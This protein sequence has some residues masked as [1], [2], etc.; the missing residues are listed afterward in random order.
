MGH[1]T[2]A[3]EFAARALRQAHHF[4]PRSGFGFQVETPAAMASLLA[5]IL[6]LTGFPDQA[7]VAASEA[8]AAAAKSGHSFSLC[9]AIS[10]GGLPVALWTGDMGEAR[11]LFELLVA[12]A[13]GMPRMELR[14]SAFARLLKLRD[15]DEDEALIA[16]FIESHGDPGLIPPFA[17]LDRN[18]E[19][20][21][22]L[23]REEPIDATW[24]TPELLRVD[25]ELLLWHAAPGAV[26]AAEAKLLRALEIAREQSA[27]SWELR[28]AMSLAQLWRHHRRATEARDLLAG[29]YRKFSEGFGTSDLIRARN[30]ITEFES[31]SAAG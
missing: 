9:Y 17:A 19:I 1:Q 16:S 25:A 18:A 24:N 20:A 10:Q 15:G 4:D 5:R 14:V 8:V 12:H 11:R 31:D 28:A 27:L 26:G 21:V 6:W 7:N 13:G 29:T 22:P 3:G 2:V 23:P 30:I